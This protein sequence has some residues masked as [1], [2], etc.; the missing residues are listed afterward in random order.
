MEVPIPNLFATVLRVGILAESQLALPW[1]ITPMAADRIRRLALAATLVCLIPRPSIATT[2]HVNQAGT[3]D[4]TTIAGGLALASAGDRVVVAAGTYP[5]YDLQLK[6]SVEL[7]SESGPVVTIIDASLQG[8][9]IIGADQATLRGFTI[10][11]AAFDAAV[12]CYQT[13]PAILDNIVEQNAG[14][15]ILLFQSTSLIQ[16]NTLRTNPSVFPI[17]GPIEAYES[18]P[19]IVQNTIEA[20]D[21]NDNGYAITLS[22][23]GPGASG[24]LV[25]DNTIVGRLYLY[26]VSGPGMTEIRRNVILGRVGSGGG[27]MN[28]S[29][30]LGPLSFHHN[31]V[32]YGFGILIQGGSA[33]TL[34]N[35]I[36]TKLS[37]STAIDLFGSGTLTLACNDLWDNR[38]NY[39]GVPPGPGD[40]NMDPLFCDAPVGDYHLSTTSPCTADHS[41]SGCGLVGAL[42]P[43]CATTP[44]VHTTWG[45][46]KAVYR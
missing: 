11:G 46:L 8:H 19:H 30:C 1:G 37:N 25:E 7:A 33:L 26:S 12:Y 28:V 21:P 32:V 45:K 42:P 14:R 36:I 22:S 4:A 10:R 3:G 41:P 15:G 31:T 9:A 13:S 2:W 24:A 17:P 23:V 5:E 6:R 16:G 44:T 35:N 18:S 38:Y 20:E 27:G 40:F 39:N 34:A 29:S 43:A